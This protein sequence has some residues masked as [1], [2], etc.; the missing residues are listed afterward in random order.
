[1]PMIS[2][3]ELRKTRE[4]EDAEAVKDK[5]TPPDQVILIGKKIRRAVL[6]RKEEDL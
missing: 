2:R 5:L 1:M 3:E 4:G 6:L